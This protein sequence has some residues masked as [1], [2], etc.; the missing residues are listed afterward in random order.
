VAKS[1][2]PAELI[3]SER[4]APSYLAVV[5]GAIYWMEGHT[6][7]VQATTSATLGPAVALGKSISHLAW[8]RGDLFIIDSGE[9]TIGRVRPAGEPVVIARGK[10]LWRLAVH[11]DHVYFVDKPVEGQA[12]VR[13]VAR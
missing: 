6:L 3:M 1:G 4:L 7:V 8:D 9:G 10:D 13:R 5:V 11:G 12:S 2:G